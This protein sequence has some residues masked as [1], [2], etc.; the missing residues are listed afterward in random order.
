MKQTTERSMELRREREGLIN[1]A[2]ALLDRVEGEK[3]NF[4]GTEKDQYAALDTQIRSL[5]E[6]IDREETQAGIEAEAR[7]RIA[8]PTTAAGGERRQLTDEQK[9]L[10]SFFDPEQVGNRRMQL[11][12]AREERALQVDSDVAGGFTVDEQSFVARLIK[13]VDDLV[14]IRQRATVIPVMSADS[15]GAPS[16]DADVADSDWTTELD[17]GTD[18]SAMT[19]GKRELHPHPLAK[20]IKVSRKLMRASALPIETLVRDRLGYKVGVTMEKGYLTGNGFG[21]PLGVFTASVNGISTAR[22]VSTGNAATEIGADGLIRCKMSVKAAYQARGRWLFHRDAVT[23]LML[24][25]DGNGQYL[26][27]TG[28][29]GGGPDLLLNSPFDMSEFAP[30]T[31]TTGQYVGIFA[32]WSQYWIADAMEMELQRLDELYAR[33]NQVGFVSRMETDGMPV[34]EEAFARVK[35]G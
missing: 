27:R 31:F 17:T 33:T 20:G 26:W 4:D 25:K 30:N 13:F 10:R 15:L 21:Q 19:F 9:A 29:V 12:G 16:L 2:R 14:Y 5:T 8:Q 23:Q 1:Q 7:E 24:L 32:D 3:R 18:D 6:R 35:L 28:L 11:R 22:D 34:L